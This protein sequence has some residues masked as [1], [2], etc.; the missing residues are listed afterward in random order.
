MSPLVAAALGRG[1]LVA[2]WREAPTA[3][4][5][6]VQYLPSPEL[7]EVGTTMCPPCRTCQEHFVNIFF[8]SC[9]SGSAWYTLLCVVSCIRFERA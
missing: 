5:D 3:V 7:A 2:A 8:D 9:Y 1:L 6:T 4:E